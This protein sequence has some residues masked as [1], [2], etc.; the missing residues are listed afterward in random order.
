MGDCILSFQVLD[1]TNATRSQRENV[2]DYCAKYGCKLLFI[3]SICDDDDILSRNIKVGLSTLWSAFLYIY[4]IH[5]VK[6]HFLNTFS[7]K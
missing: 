2:C 4:C 6:A 7:L 1:G 3:E 5:C